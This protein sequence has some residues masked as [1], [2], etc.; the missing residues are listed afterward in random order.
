VHLVDSESWCVADRPFLHID[1]VVLVASEQDAA[2]HGHAPATGL[3]LGLLL[4]IDPEI[5]I[6]LIARLGRV[7]QGEAI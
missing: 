6:R 3:G 1:H 4:L 2:G 7:G 5:W